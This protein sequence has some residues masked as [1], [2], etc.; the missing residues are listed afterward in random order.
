MI[1]Y[2]LIEP[3]L[4]KVMRRAGLTFLNTNLV[5]CHSSPPHLNPR[6]FIGFAIREIDDRSAQSRGYIKRRVSFTEYSRHKVT[7]QKR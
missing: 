7:L 4:T 6:A 5:D 1:K 2:G 3:G